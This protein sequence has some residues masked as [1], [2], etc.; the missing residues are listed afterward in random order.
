M[1]IAGHHLGCGRGHEPERG[2]HVGLDARVDVGV[3]AHRAREL[4]HGHGSA[5][6]AQAV[7][8]TGHLQAPQRARDAERG[9]LGVDAVR[10]PDHGRVAMAPGQLDEGRQQRVGGGEQ[11]IAGR[12]E[13]RA[14]RRV[15][16]V[17]R[18][19][20]E[21]DPARLGPA[22]GRLHHVDERSD[23]VVRDALALG[24]GGHERVVDLR[25]SGATGCPA[26]DGRDADALHGLHGQ[27][28]HGEVRGEAAGVGE[29]RSQLGRLIP[30]DHE[31]RT[32][33][34]RSG[35]VPTNEIGTPMCLPTAAR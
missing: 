12:G 26:T 31:N 1:T 7:A 3:R 10:A 11:V 25:R 5:G 35:P 34:S 20:P 14:P 4:A 16:H 15:D 18:G 29:E 28:L 9:G 30:L 8:V 19:E 23:I 33:W 21:V 22:D 32:Y 24:H 17:G 13:Q 2:A 6:G 27:Q